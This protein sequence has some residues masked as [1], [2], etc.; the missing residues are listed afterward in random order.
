MMVI[1]IVIIE[2]AIQFLVIKFAFI[3]TSSDGSVGAAFSHMEAHGAADDG[4][5]HLRYFAPTL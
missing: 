1:L 2:A 5:L 3:K 4:Y